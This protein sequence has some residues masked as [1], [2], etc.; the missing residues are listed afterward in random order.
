MHEFDDLK[1]LLQARSPLIVIESYEELRALQL[2]RRL[3]VN[4]F[5]PL[6]Q[7]SCTEGLR[8]LDVPSDAQT[9]NTEPQQVLAQIKGTKNPGIYVLCDFH[10][11][12]TEPRHIRFL[13]EI[14]LL[15]DTVGHTVVLLSHSL[16]IPAEL[17]RLCYRFELHLPS[18]QQVRQLVLEA[19]E[20]YQQRTGELADL[21]PDAVQQLV[22]NLRG[23]TFEEVKRLAY[24]AIA[25]DGAISAADVS[26]VNQAKFRLLQTEGVLSQVYDTKALDDV[27][28]LENLK[29]WLLQR[30]TAFVQQQRDTP[31]GVLLTGVQG[32]G[33]SL[34]AKAIA[35][36]F[37]VPLLLLDMASLY[38]KYIGETEKNLR[39]ALQLADAMAPCV[40]WIDEIEKG[41][42]SGQGDQGVGRRLLG[43]LLTWMAERKAAVFLVATA[44]NIHELAPELLRKGRFDELFFVDLPEADER[45]ALLQL[46]LQRRG[47]VLDTEAL[48][49]LLPLTSGFSGAELEQAVVGA[50]FRAQS[51][52]TVLGPHHLEQE[53]GQTQP[54][55]VVM[56]ESVEALRHWASSRCVR[57]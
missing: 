20:L 43:T 54:I 51:D 16:S 22:Q 15:H 4:L 10:P 30:R 31:K 23:L 47:L 29:S 9:F 48:T 8:R 35:G 1:I 53:L 32:T 6:F 38:N 2:I 57:A 18:D 13:K 7:W 56:A 40:L 12:L 24:K 3:A 52:A 25:N 41:I 5:R 44:N 19:A 49:K 50:S 42:S 28:G 14:A 37:G 34:A 26:R 55:S 11:F 21:Q 17:A 36:A 27:V 45:L 33:K 46:H 39:Q